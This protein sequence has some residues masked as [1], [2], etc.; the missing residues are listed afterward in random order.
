MS[1]SSICLDAMLGARLDDRGVAFLTKARGELASGVEN[2]RFCALLSQASRFG[3][4]GPLEPTE[5]ERAA[6][7]AALPGWEVERWTRVEALRVALILSR[8]DLAEE[9][10]QAAIEEAFGFADMGEL[11]ALYRSLAHLPGPERFLWRSCEGARTNMRSVFE[12][13]ICDTPYP[14][15]HFDDVAWRQAVVKCLF[16]EAPLWRIQGLDGRLDEELARMALDLSEERTS[17][18]RRVYPE[19][20]LCLGSHGGE[21]A[22]ARIEQMFAEGDTDQRRAA[23]LAFAR[24]GH[25]DRL[26]SLVAVEQDEAVRDTM[27]EALAGHSDQGAFR[28]LDPEAQGAC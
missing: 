13:N 2:G 27:N 22:L 14:A 15:A 18:G 28:A 26:R 17:A 20:L 8:G 12:A 6:C 4:R 1:A 24:A 25:T 16:V 5:E 7:A 10:A 21:R 19:L 9:G 11:C 23:A 3:G